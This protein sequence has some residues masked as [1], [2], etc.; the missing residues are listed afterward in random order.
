MELNN[1][2]EK[3]KVDKGNHSLTLEISK[4]EFDKIMT[5]NI[6]DTAFNLVES[7]LKNREDDG[8]ASNVNLDYDINNKIVKI[9]ADVEY[10][11]N[12]HTDY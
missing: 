7:H 2:I 4:S 5:G 1:I 6:E 3:R 10:L 11:G 9:H 12:K 8:R